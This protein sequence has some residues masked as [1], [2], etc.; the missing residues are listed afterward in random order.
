MT[1]RLLWLLDSLGVGG[2]EALV[3]PFARQLDRR[4]YTLFVGCLWKIEGEMVVSGLR[5]LGVPAIEFAA[6]S[7][8]DRTTYRVVRKFIED[9]QIDLVHAHLTFSA[10]WSA[11]LSRQ[12]GIPSVATLHVAPSATR[13]FRNTLRHRLVT[14]ARDWVMR[15]TMN[16][17][18]SRV[19]TVS[20]ALRQTYLA[21]RDLAPEKVTVVHNGIELERFRRDRAATRARLEREFDIPAGKPILVT[22]SVLRPAKGIEFLLEAAKRVD[23]AVFLILGDG[24]KREEWQALAAQQGIGDRVRWAGYRTDVDTI[25]AG[26]DALVHPSLDDA[27]PTVLL[28]AMAAGLPVVAT[29]VGGIP[30]IV[31]DGATGILV[32]PADAEALASGIGELL[33]DRERMRRMGALATDSAI[34]RFSTAAWVSRLT[35]V[36][37]EVLRRPRS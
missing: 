10:T 4:K 9:E 16:R 3:V 14:D 19:I 29:R 32:P 33:S 28:E 37:D 22:V 30:E 2:A 6:R 26:C 35:A 34:T 27:F 12:T 20:E 1:T 15:Q 21:K 13:Q 23:N 17:W 11:L 18:S 24:N 8:R 7:L 31:N 5:E 36:Y 25:L